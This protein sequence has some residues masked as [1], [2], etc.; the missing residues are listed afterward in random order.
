M[1]TEA[2]SAD[3]TPRWSANALR[4]CARLPLL[5]PG[6]PRRLVWL[7][8]ALSLDE[9][10]D[11]LARVAEELVEQFP[12]RVTTKEL[13][14]AEQSK[15]DQEVSIVRAAHA[16]SD[17]ERG[18]RSSSSLFHFDL[19][20]GDDGEPIYDLWNCYTT[21]AELRQRCRRAALATL[22]AV[23]RDFCTGPVC[24][25]GDEQRACSAAKAVY[26]EDPSYLVGSL[27]SP[28]FRDLPEALTQ[29]MRR[30]I[31]AVSEAFYLTNIGRKVWAAIDRCLEDRTGGVIEGKSGRGKSAAVRA[32]CTAHA[33]EARLVTL[34]GYGNGLSVF[35]AIA[36]S[37]GLGT[38]YSHSPGQLRERVA[39]VLRRSGL[40]LII[41]EA[42]FLLPEPG[43][44]RRP[45]LLDWLNADMRESGV[46]VVLVTTE[47]FAPGSGRLSGR[48]VGTRSNSGVAS[49]VNG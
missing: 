23:L 35:R 27:F 7:L 32:W 11:R 38:S 1:S 15:R 42:H 48:M 25:P 3:S 26:S 16:L 28:V 31:A 46:P 36:S 33:G 41:D 44:R 17:Y 37:L 5:P 29:W 47:Q 9:Q 12:E 19:I 18:Y 49:P 10:R 45:E 43:R 24:W 30:H 13:V 34:R 20:R 22:P 6:E 8:Q 39:D 14:E 40:G 21:V 4:V 2:P